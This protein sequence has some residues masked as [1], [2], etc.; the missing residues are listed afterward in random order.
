MA[1]DPFHM[2]SYWRD[3]EG[4]VHALENHYP[5]LLKAR[6][7]LHAAVHNVRVGLGYLE[8]ELGKLDDGSG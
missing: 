3:K 7:D 5:E 1:D 4:T 2:F 6:P 8:S